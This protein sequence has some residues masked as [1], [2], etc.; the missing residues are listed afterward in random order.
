MKFLRVILS[1]QSESKAPVSAT[2]QFAKLELVSLFVF[3]SAI[4]DFAVP[5]FIKGFNF[6]L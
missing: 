1:E 4:L 6:V 3:G 5:V 2:Q